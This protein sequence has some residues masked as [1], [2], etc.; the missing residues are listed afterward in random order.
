MLTQRP[1]GWNGVKSGAAV[2]TSDVPSDAPFATSDARSGAEV[3]RRPM[4][5]RSPGIDCLTWMLSTLSLVRPATFESIIRRA[6]VNA[7]YGDSQL[8]CSSA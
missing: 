2:V 7:S 4:R 6:A 8:F 1:L 5:P 3:A